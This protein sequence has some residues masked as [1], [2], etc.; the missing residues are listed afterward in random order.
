MIPTIPF[1]PWCQ[2]D[3]LPLHALKIHVKYCEKA[4][5]PRHKQREKRDGKR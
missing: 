1:C 5:R 3:D 2:R 4:P